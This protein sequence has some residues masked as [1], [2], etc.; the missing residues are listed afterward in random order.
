MINSD[1]DG[2]VSIQAVGGEHHILKL[3]H[4]SYNVEK[5]LNA[6]ELKH[7]DDNKLH[8]LVICGLYRLYVENAQR[9]GNRV[10]LWDRRWRKKLWGGGRNSVRSVDRVVRRPKWLTRRV[11][12]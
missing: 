11:N 7:D 10:T 4:A 9:N 12:M 1:L 5:L 6:L 3:R 2:F 8:N